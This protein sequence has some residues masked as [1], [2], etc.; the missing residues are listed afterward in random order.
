MLPVTENW[1]G[2]D[3]VKAI[4]LVVRA[5]VAAAKDVLA[6]TGAAVVAAGLPADPSAV[7]QPVR[8][9]RVAAATAITAPAIRR[10]T[11]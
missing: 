10:F 5:A 8:P 11:G 9:S 3:M 1:P 2:S 7:A 6:S 4:G